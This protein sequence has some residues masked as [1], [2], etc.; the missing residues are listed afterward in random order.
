MAGTTKPLLAGEF[1]AGL[2]RERLPERYAM[3][4]ALGAP[5]LHAV[6]FS[7]PLLPASVNHYTIPNGRGGWFKSKASQAFT[8]AVCIFGRPQRNASVFDAE[9]YE[10]DLVF[11]VEEKH[12][13]R[14]DADNFEKL[15]FDGLKAAGIIRDDRYIVFHSN[16]KIPVATRN[17]ERTEYV[18]TGV[19]R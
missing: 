11:A 13:L 5:A 12:F 19:S 1:F 16:R 4:E 6:R 17:E 9:F 2:W 10:V 3:A 7:V 15:A 18:V 8:D 14:C